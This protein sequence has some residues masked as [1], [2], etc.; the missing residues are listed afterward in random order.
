[1]KTLRLYALF[2][3]IFTVSIQARTDLGNGFYLEDNGVTV[4]CENNTSASS[5]EYNGKIYT[6]ITAK[7]QLTTESGGTVAP[8]NAC[9]SGITSMFEWFK[10]K[11]T[12]DDNISHWDTSKVTNMSSMFKSATIFNQAI[13]DWNTSKVTNMSSMFSN[14]TTFNQ[15][16]GDWNT[17]KVTNMSSMFNYASAFNQPISNWN[18]SKVTGMSSMFSNATAFNQP[19]SNWNTSK[20]TTMSSMFN[21]AS[22]F[23]QPIGNWNTSSVTNMSSMFKSATIFNQPIG[24]WNTSKVTN[25]SSMFNYASAF[26]QPIGDW[27][28]SKVTTMSSMF[29]NA[30]A[31]N[32]DIGDWNT[33]SVINMSSMFNVASAFNQAIGNWDTSHV[34][35]MSS[36]FKSAT[37]FNQAIGDWNTS[38]VTIMSNMFKNAS[39]F[40]QCLKSWDV[41]LIGSKPTSFDNASGFVGQT[42]KQPI[43]ATIGTSCNV[44][45]TANHFTYTTPI[46][47]S[48]KTFDWN[49]SSSASDSNGD[50][51]SATVKTQ[52]SKGSATISDTNI[53]YT[54]NANQ[55][56]SDRVIITISDGNGAVDI[57][58]TLEGIDTLAPSQP[59]IHSTNGTTITG[60]GEAGATI[61]LKDDSN[62]TIGTAIVDSN[63]T[64]SIT[65]A[66]P[67]SSGTALS[68]TQ[69]DTNGN[70]SVASS[71]ISV[72]PSS[73]TDMGN[74]FWLES[75]GVTI[76]CDTNTSA[77]TT[78]NGKTYT[79]I[80]AKEELTTYIGSVE[81]ANACTSGVTNMSEWF[82]NKPTFNDNISHWDT[83]SVTNMSDMFHQATAFNQSIGNWNISSVTDMFGMFQSATAF[84]Q[85]IGD[86]NTSKVTDMGSMFAN[87]TAF[88]QS[89]GNWNTSSVTN[90]RN[91][92]ANATA[93]NQPIGDW[94]TSS[95]TEMRNMFSGANTLSSAN[96]CAIVKGWNKD[97]TYANATLYITGS[98]S[99]FV[100]EVCRDRTP[101]SFSFTA[102][103]NQA[104]ST[105]LT[106]NSV[107]I[108]G[109]DVNT[110]VS[111]SGGE[112]EINGDGNWT[113]TSSTVDS[114]DT[115]K[116]RLTSSSS[117]STKVS[118]TLTVGT[119]SQAFDVTTLNAPP[120]PPTASELAMQKVQQ[121]IKDNAT[122]L[123][124][125]QELNAISGVSGAVEGVEYSNALANG[126]YSDKANPTSQE[127][128]AI[129]NAHNQTLLE[130]P[131]EDNSTTEN[132]SSE[133]T[134]EDNTTSGS[135]VST[136]PNENKA[137]TEEP[138]VEDNSTNEPTTEDN[139]TI[140]EPTTEDNTTVENNTTT[141][142]PT[143]EENTTTEEPKVEDNS[144][145]EPT[146]E[147]N[148]TT[149]EPTVE[150]N[151]TNEPVVDNNTTAEDNATIEEPT[152]EDNTTNP[153]PFVMQVL[154][155][156][157]SFSP[158]LDIETQEDDKQKQARIITPNGNEIVI[159]IDKATQRV[160]VS[161]TNPNTNQTQTF[162]I[163]LLG[164]QISVDEE[165][166]ILIVTLLDNGAKAHIT[167]KA[168]GTIEHS[169]AYLDKTTQ[170]T[171]L[172][173]DAN[174]S[175]D[176]NG[177][178]ETQARVVREDFI[179]KAVVTTNKEGKSKTKFIKLN[180]A[181]GE[182]IDLDHTL[183]NDMLF[184]EGSIIEILLI[185]GTI[186]IKTKTLLDRDLVIE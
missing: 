37:I 49:T 13:G 62:N 57:N 18:T 170:A 154:Q 2:L 116:V 117:Y 144:T 51:L 3:M 149:E 35:N 36:M 133:P 69:S 159:I 31:F 19:I 97:E 25:M 27:N 174:T 52:G 162:A 183:R 48:A 21:V 175:I 79:K 70:T 95:V 101:D 84:N 126:T 1:M 87:A 78:Y 102:L 140:E 67:V 74:G 33:S 161:I 92:F 39:A 61:T 59:T 7:T 16:I 82:W 91:M 137:T 12:F 75:N 127:I 55:S 66:T 54:P 60:T 96:E 104:R 34:T 176:T 142:E 17:S 99:G 93:F 100:M 151:S 56:G 47:S 178:V 68:A 32:Q 42:D 132:N 77:S 58:I 165:G 115:L 29:S 107:T 122:T 28:T 23:N 11:T 153:Q 114:G 136:S 148:T 118:A 166:N 22:A 147:D 146:T 131:T 123:I 20:V 120:P 150:D 81:P 173:E 171:T 113:T 38:K 9:T 167:I 108:N 160:R 134:T 179:F 26:N 46:G 40:N 168:D 143:V 158:N 53:T 10:D 63:G 64:W 30:I 89:I 121:V 94:D 180:L 129:I 152:T 88:D 128:Q 109:I 72:L 181:T 41:H 86:W 139:T 156:L 76:N 111:I 43:W 185:D 112:Y 71:S 24:D 105:L 141:E 177:T 138:T 98:N 90:M 182:E 124:T 103:T 14:A 130:T 73:W 4:T 125:S 169:V 163:E 155:T 6:K 157:A 85:P 164:S 106:S 45:P 145:N 184:E 172:I 135:E 119:A 110:S 83:S 15:A 65:P 80:T 44:A 50:S 8:A 186:H 5:N